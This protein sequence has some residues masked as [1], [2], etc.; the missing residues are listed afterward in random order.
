MDVALVGFIG[1][2]VFGG[3]R[4]GFLKR[5]IGL[6]FA[7]ISLVA[8][9]YFRYP[10]G[11]I[12]SALFPKIPSDYADLVGYTI[13][14]PVILAGLHLTSR[15]L[16]RDVNVQGLTKEADQAL[17]A[18]FGGLEA[19]V[20]VSAAIVI[21]D[22]Y[23]RT[24]TGAGVLAGDASLLKQLGQAMDGSTTVKLLRDT[25]VPLTLAVLGPILPKDISTL[26]SNGLPGLPGGLPLPSS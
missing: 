7:A 20:I 13:A 22:T 21:F 26:L 9:A 18:V 2:F 10:V 12:A 4:T 17:G 1:G 5:L 8:S 24:G 19:I 11:A 3:W 25:T 14:F 6:G 23:F 15:R 16:L